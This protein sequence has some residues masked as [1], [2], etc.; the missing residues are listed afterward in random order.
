MIEQTLGLPI[1]IHGGGIDLI[2]PHHENEMA[3]GVCA[4][5]DH[6]GYARYWMHN[7]FLNM[8]DEKMSKS[9]GNVALAHDLVKQVPGRGDP[10]G[11]AGRPLPRAAGLD[12]RPD[13]AG[14]Q[15]RSTGSTARCAGRRRRSRRRGAAAARRSSWRRCEDDLN[16]PRRHGRAVR[17]GHRRWRPR[18][19][20]RAAAER[21][22]ASCWP[23][24]ACMGFL[25]ADPEAWFQGGVDEDL[26][27]RIEALIAARVAARAAK[28]WAEADRI[29]A[30]LTALERRGDGRPHRRDLADQGAGLMARQARRDV[31]PRHRLQVPA[32]AAAGRAAEGRAPH[33]RPGAGR[34]D[35][36]DRLRPGAWPTGTRSIRKAEGQIRIGDDA[37]PD[38]GPAGRAAADDPAR[39]CSTGCRTS[40]STG[41]CRC[42]A[43]WCT[44]IRYIEIEK[45]GEENCIV[46]NGELFDGPAGAARSASGRPRTLRR[47]FA[48]MGEALKA[49]AEAAWRE[50][51]GAPT[52]AP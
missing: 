17:A 52:S 47:G 5:H 24:P 29:R 38:P 28:D 42:W 50:R 51:G 16:T 7:G 44:T 31:R 48:A 18:R 49:R 34:G 37:D 41:G 32:A 39:W 19:R 8:G 15:A 35:L 14:P 9:L 1:D 2:F 30:E 11:A 27:A 21:Q 40:S 4:D 13:R 12:R 43:G 33:R 25:Q 46:S 20:R 10:L 6:D 22:G 3:Q 45:L 23:R 36:G 26:K